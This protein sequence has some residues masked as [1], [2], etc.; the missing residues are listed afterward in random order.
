MCIR[1]RETRTRNGTTG[2]RANY[3]RRI[4]RF[5]AHSTGRGAAIEGAALSQNLTCRQIQ[6]RYLAC[7]QIC[8]TPL[9][10]NVGTRRKSFYRQFWSEGDLLFRKIRVGTP[11]KNFLS[12][13]PFLRVL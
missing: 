11:Q 9:V 3:I 2:S 6:R 7:R 10:L 8:S 4:V 1:E 5:Y 12:L 13:R